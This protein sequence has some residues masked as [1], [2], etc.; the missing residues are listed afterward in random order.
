M[1]NYHCAVR[2][3]RFRVID[4][5]QFM[6]YMKRVEVD[7]GEITIL[8]D[9]DSSGSPIYGFSANG[10]ILGVSDYSEESVS[11]DEDMYDNFIAGLQ[12]IVSDDDAIII[13]EVG[14][15]NTD[16]LSSTATIVT[17]FDTDYIDLQDVA[18][19]RAIELLTDIR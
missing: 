17:T 1:A 2:T 15:S 10:L 6:E 4:E 16:D 11:I 18:S 13:L 9:R 14:F 19:D 5:N 3:N 12:E 7:G 8:K